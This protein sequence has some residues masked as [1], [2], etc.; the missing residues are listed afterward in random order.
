MSYTLDLI[1]MSIGIIRLFQLVSKLIIF[2]YTHTLF[3]YICMYQFQLVYSFHTYIYDFH[4]LNL[5]LAHIYKST[6]FMMK[7]KNFGSL[8]LPLISK[9]FNFI[10]VKF[11][12]VS[13]CFIIMTIFEPYR[14]WVSTLV[15]LVWFM[16]NIWFDFMF[17]RIFN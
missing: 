3:S 8:C 12:L 9:C 4:V 11:Q 1:V 15:Y 6:K 14:F 17:W 10:F 5:Q 2:V 16:K 7:N 13:I